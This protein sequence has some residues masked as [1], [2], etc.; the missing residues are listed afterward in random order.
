MK[1][2]SPRLKLRLALFAGLASASVG[3]VASPSLPVQ[4]LAPKAERISS[5][6]FLKEISSNQSA[7]SAEVLAGA[8]E[9]SRATKPLA[10][11]QA[12][13]GIIIGLIL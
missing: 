4:A 13:I 11:A 9:L 6:A 10:A 12:N 1:M 5:A 7:G 3:A 2:L 8:K